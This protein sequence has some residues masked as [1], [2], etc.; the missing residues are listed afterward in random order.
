MNDVVFVTGSQRKADYLA[1][2]L[3]HPIEHM[4]LDLDEVQSLNLK[5]VVTHKVR[6]AY[7]KVQRPVLVEDVSLEMPA[8]GR[9]PGTFIR[10]FIEELSLEGVCRLLD[11]KERNAVVR[12]M[13]GYADGTKEEFFES[14]LTGTISKKPSSFIGFGGFDPIFIPEGY[15]VPRSELS[16]EDDHKT[17][18]Q[19]KPIE[20]VKDFLRSSVHAQP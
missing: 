13:Y 20:K 19:I 1:E 10:W 5:D 2:L 16:R 14:A 8:L 7:Q 12:C 4:K 18:L 11:G 9:L 17:Y 6:Q 15:T 3:G